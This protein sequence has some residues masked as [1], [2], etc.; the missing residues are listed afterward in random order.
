MTPSLTNARTTYTL[1]SIA[2]WPFR[3]IAA[4]IAVFRE[5][6]GP[7]AWVPMLLGAGRILRPVQC[8]NFGPRNLKEK[9]LWEPTEVALNLFVEALRGNVR[10]AERYGSEEVHVVLF[11]EEGQRT[12]PVEVRETVRKYFRTR[13]TPM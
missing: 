1:I 3:T 2:R 12:K 8:F 7:K 11:P 10:R 13:L 5:C 6:I 4:M 9:I